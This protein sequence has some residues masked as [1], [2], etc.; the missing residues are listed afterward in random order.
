MRADGGAEALAA[1]GWNGTNGHGD[2]GAIAA[3]VRD[4]QRRFGARVVEV[5]ADTLELSVAAP[6]ASRSQALRVAAEHAAFCPDNVFQ[7][8]D[9][10]VGGSFRRRGRTA[11]RGLRLNCSWLNRR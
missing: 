3:V 6:Q 2:S 8:G 9:G 5:G 10:G 11:G 4:W 7:R 1:C